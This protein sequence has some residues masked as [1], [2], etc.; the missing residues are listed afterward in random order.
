[1]NNISGTVKWLSALGLVLMLLGMITLTV[2]FEN[3]GTS[4]W[5]LTP[6]HS[7]TLLDLLSTALMGIGIGLVLLAAYVWDK[8]YG[9]RQ[10]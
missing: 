5:N 4:L 7:I 3:E 10:H 9:K 6:Q 8:T 1:M 2:P